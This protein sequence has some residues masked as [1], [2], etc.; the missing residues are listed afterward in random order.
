M[1]FKKKERKKTLKRAVQ[2]ARREQAN[3]VLLK[4]TILKSHIKVVLQ[5][6][7]K[8]VCSKKAI[9]QLSRNIKDAMTGNKLMFRKWEAYPYQE[10]RKAH[11]IWQVNHIPQ[12]KRA[13][14][15]CELSLAKS[16]SKQFF[17]QQRQ[18][19]NYFDDKYVKKHLGKTR[20]Q[21]KYSVSFM[22]Q[23]F[24]LKT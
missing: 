4:N 8:T 5:F 20:K 6:E 17:I 24:P 10:N 16:D 3:Q 22:Y 12:I 13:K 2:K 14:K 11:K 9:S 7:K 23:S 21:Q 1:K 15:E 19:A 18:E